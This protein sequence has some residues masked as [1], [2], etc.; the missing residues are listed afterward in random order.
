MKNNLKI[1][2][3]KHAEIDSEK[4]NRCIDRAENCRIYGYDWHLDRTAEI[5]DALIVGDYEFVMPLPYKIKLGIKYLYQPL[6]S[7]QLGIFP[8][9]PDAV[10]KQFFDLLFHYFRY[11][12]FQ[13]NSGNATVTPD[14]EID[15]IPRKNYLLDLTR[16]YSELS[17]AFSTNT[18]RNIKKANKNSLTLIRGIGL[19]EYLDFKSENLTAGLNESA[20]K[21]LKN[22]IAYGQHKG[23][24][25]IY[26]VYTQGNKLCAAAYFCRWKE[27]AIYLNAVSNEEGKKLG[28]M[29]YL[30]DNFIKTHAGQNVIIDFEG[31]M[32][33]GLQRFYSGFGAIAETYFQLKFNRLPLF[34]K[35]L[36]RK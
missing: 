21:S 31:S 9:P 16:N 33:S 4:W 29:Y 10:K 35:W 26:G 28:G 7:Q 14:N 3:F 12:D 36:K 13:I 6:Y 22:V 30:V 17:K 20:M 15:F 32:I 19:E 24:G 5:W 18:K 1:K 25:E 8:N 34:L 27:R 11:A 2:Y 23:F